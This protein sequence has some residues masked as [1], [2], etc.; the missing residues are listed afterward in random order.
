M[1]GI[2]R[3]TAERLAYYILRVSTQEARALSSAIIELKRHV[4]NCSKCFGISVDEVC[5]ICADPTRDRSVICVVEE[6]KDLI[7]VEK[8]GHYK[9]LYHVLQGHISPLDNV[10]PEDLTIERLMDRIKDSAVKEVILATNLDVEGDTTALY[11]HKRLS[12]LGRQDVK[13]TRPAR[14]IPQ[15]SYLEYLPSTVLAE[16]MDAR[17]T[18]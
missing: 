4:K 1:P 5:Q 11:I 10:H 14:G 7:S 12:A 3:K 6:P 13:V 2:G 9:G 15:G 17:M 16:A 18:F 8:T